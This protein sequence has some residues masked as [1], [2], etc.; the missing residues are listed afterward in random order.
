MRAVLIALA[1][2][3][4]VFSKSE[5]VWAIDEKGVSVSLGRAS[6]SCGKWT[7][8][9]SEKIKGNSRHYNGYADWLAG[10]FTAYNRWIPGKQRRAEKMD[11]DGLMAWVDNYCAANPLKK[12]SSAASALIQHIRVTDGMTPEQITRKMGV[13]KVRY[14]FVS[15]GNMKINGE[16]VNV[17]KGSE[18]V[19]NLR[20]LFFG[21]GNQI[22][23]R[24]SFPPPQRHMLPG[25]SV[26]FTT[27]IPNPPTNAKRIHVG[28]DEN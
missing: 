1:I 17:S 10:Y 28:L 11:L 2:L 4:V 12:V 26:Y 8:A 22:I 6:D 23:K 7:T 24:W 27:E 16:L 21:A 15:A 25:E 9:T 14:K 5:T 3:V 20:V 18:S 19:P 13:R